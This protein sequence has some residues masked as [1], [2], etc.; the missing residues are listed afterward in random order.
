MSI[1]SARYIFVP[2]ELADRFI[3]VGSPQTV[4]INKVF[5]QQNK[6]HIK[7]DLK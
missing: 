5:N 7:D 6:T 1:H 2:Q 3:S 4:K